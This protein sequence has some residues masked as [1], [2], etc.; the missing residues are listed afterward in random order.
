[1][2]KMLDVADK[3]ECH[4]C[5]QVFTLIKIVLRTFC[6]QDLLICCLKMFAVWLLGTLVQY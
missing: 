3:T 1:M 4:S 5:L 6:Q 2:P